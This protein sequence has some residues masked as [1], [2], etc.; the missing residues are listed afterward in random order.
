MH[1]TIYLH[2]FWLSRFVLNRNSLSLKMKT[3]VHNFIFH[4]LVCLFVA[5]VALWRDHAK[6][7]W[8]E[9]TPHQSAVSVLILNVRSE[10]KGAYED[11]APS[12]WLINYQLWRRRV[13]VIK[14]LSSYSPSRN[15]RLIPVKPPLKRIQL[16]DEGPQAFVISYLENALSICKQRRKIC[17]GEIM[18]SATLHC[19]R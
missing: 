10:T 7:G 15:F 12:N 2:M 11:A 4:K 6:Y 1:A 5:S 14:Q 17:Q 16:H 18:H 9:I 13:W 8:C 19:V 3:F